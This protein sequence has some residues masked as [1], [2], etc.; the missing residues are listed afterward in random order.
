[1]S[2]PAD[3]T[4]LE[5]VGAVSRRARLSDAALRRVAVALGIVAFVELLLILAIARGGDPRFTLDLNVFVIAF[6]AIIAGFSISGAVVARQQPHNVIGFVMLAFAVLVAFDLVAFGYAAIGLPPNPALPLANWALWISGSFWVLA[7]ALPLG[8]F[9]LRFPDGTVSE[10]GRWAQRL[11]IIGAVAY[12]LGEALGPGELNAEFP[13]IVNPIGAPEEYADVLATLAGI[14]NAL[15]VLGAVLAAIALV[16]RYRQSGSV[17]R[18]QIRW[19]AFIATLVAP[20]LTIATLQAGPISDAAF[21]L[22][23]FCVALFPVAILIAITRYRLYEIDRIVNRALLYGSLTAILAGAFAASIT[24]SQRLFVAATG[25]TSDAAI[26]AS[27]L[28][29]TAVYTPARRRIERIVDQLFKYESRRFG[30]Y[31]SEIQQALDVLDPPAA[32]ERLLAE[33]VDT[34]TATGGAVVDHAERLIATRGTWPVPIEIRLVL[35]DPARRMGWL[36][37]GP[38]RDGEPHDPRTVTELEDVCRLAGRA[39]AIGA[40]AHAEGGLREGASSEAHTEADVAAGRRR[41]ARTGTLKV[42]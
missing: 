36:L 15:I 21:A 30:P 22:G 42:Q 8:T 5:G 6:I 4:T 38:R 24:L 10:R 1:M 35:G 14:G 33:S 41:H 16:A 31:R 11:L 39:M 17:Q 32:T 12:T 25:E 3:L 28:I 13:G 27:T 23:F 7:I 34:V 19:I 18:A 20:L 40:V 37:L 2:Q 29:V 9:M 26:V